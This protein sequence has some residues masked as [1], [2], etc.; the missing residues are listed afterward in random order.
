MTKTRDEILAQWERPMGTTYYLQCKVGEFVDEFDLIEDALGWRNMGIACFIQS[1]SKFIPG[2]SKLIPGK[3]FKKTTLLFPARFLTTE[4]IQI[5]LGD[6][7]IGKL[8]DEFSNRLRTE[9]RD[10]AREQYRNEDMLDHSL[11]HNLQEKFEGEYGEH[12]D[13]G[14]IDFDALEKQLNQYINDIQR[15]WRQKPRR[16]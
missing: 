13:A 14:L 9:V 12:P 5:C 1:E 11:F 7:R 4:E 16:R 10:T 8:L 2:Q 6:R 15:E 3:L